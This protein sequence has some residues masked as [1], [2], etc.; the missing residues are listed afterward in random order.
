[1]LLP[2]SKTQAARRKSAGMKYDVGCTF[3]VGAVYLI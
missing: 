3:S 1:M 2:V